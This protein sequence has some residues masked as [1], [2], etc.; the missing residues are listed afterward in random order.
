M[1]SKKSPNGSL[2]KI[3]NSS[4]PRSS[5][6]SILESVNSPSPEYEL[7]GSRFGFREGVAGRTRN[8]FPAGGLGRGRLREGVSLPLLSE[9]AF[10]LHCPP[11]GF[12]FRRV[13]V[14]D[15]DFE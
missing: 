7:L 4:F 1:P 9:L 5:R 11:G 2:M 14:T 13:V 12:I 15:A 8:D 10:L 6:S 3:S